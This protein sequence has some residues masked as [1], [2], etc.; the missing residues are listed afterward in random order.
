MAQSNENNNS[1]NS[2][3]NKWVIGTLSTLCFVFGS[4][5]IQNVNADISDL[6]TARTEVAALVYRQ[7]ERLS[8]ME[9]RE[10]TLTEM[11]EQIQ[12]DVRETR[13]AVIRSGR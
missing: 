2:N 8:A 7:G 3:W 6:A 4:L 12:K 13:D 1:S 5:Y 11:L 10:K 9:E